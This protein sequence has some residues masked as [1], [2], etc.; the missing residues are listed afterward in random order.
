METL[1]L[2]VLFLR[3]ALRSRMQY[4]SNVFVGIVSL[5]IFNGVNLALIS[6]LLSRFQ[7]IQGWQ[8]W[9]IVML[10][11]MWMLSHCIYSMFFWHLTTFE[12]DIIQGVF[13][14]Y[15][16]RPCS[17]L[18]QLL[19]RGINFM[20]MSDVVFG[21]IAFV[22]AYIRLGAH[23]TLGQWLFFVVAILSGTIIETC[24]I[25][26]IASWSFWIGRTSAT[27]GAVVHFNLLIQQ[28]P[29]DMFG[30]W[31]QVFMTGFLP[32]AFINYYP[33]T[34]L[35]GKTNISSVRGVAFLSPVVAVLLIAVGAVIWTRG[36][37]RYTSSGN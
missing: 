31:F 33:L 1:R 2:Y 8:Y 19:G 13:D 10:Y 25:W 14:Q 3:L 9:E 23:W 18:M 37:Q 36:V 7:T 12:N 27:A 5:M 16:I 34:V 29:L 26:I 20:G 17:P 22:V 28:Y 6:V 30:K 21:V 11:S 4:R 24:I 32:F 35:L 15:L